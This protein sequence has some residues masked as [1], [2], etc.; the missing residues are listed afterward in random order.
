ML[1][2]SL[3]RTGVVVLLGLLGSACSPTLELPDAGFTLLPDRSITPPP[4]APMVDPPPAV[5]PYQIVTFRGTAE[6][7]RVFVTADGLNP[8]A[9]TLGSGGDFCVDVRVT[10]PGT[11]LFD[12][13]AYGQ[14]NQI[15]A[16]LP[17]KISVTY[18]PSAPQIGDSLTTCS[19]VHPRGCTG[20]IEICDDGIDNDCNNLRD[21]QDPACNPCTDDQ[22]E[23]NDNQSAASVQPGHYRGLMICP[24]DPDFYGIY[25]R[26]GERLTAQISFPHPEGNLDMD[27]LSV[28]AGNPPERMVLSRSDTQMD[29]EIISYTA[30]VT[31][32]HMLSVFGSMSTANAY[33][34]VIRLDNN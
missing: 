4:G 14:D 24:A 20:Q 28:K 29:S 26:R 13:Q 9:A 10:N 27:L 16:P 19:G 32:V 22:F 3:P 18:D 7:R 8:E 34:L 17:Q 31:G 15:G 11:Y 12:L 5:T 6:G 25:V 1:R 23:D 30:T 21:M 33:D 2:P